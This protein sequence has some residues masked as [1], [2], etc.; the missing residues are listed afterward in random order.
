MIFVFFNGSRFM[1]PVFSIQQK[2]HFAGH[3]KM[4]TQKLSPAASAVGSYL[5]E[6]MFTIH[7]Q[8]VPKSA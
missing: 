7:V 3:G 2:N 6:Q 5:D 1:A 4:A 8:H